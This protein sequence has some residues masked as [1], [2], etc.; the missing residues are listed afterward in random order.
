MPALLS[1]G[2]IAGCSVID[3]CPRFVRRFTKR[4]S[5]FL[6]TPDRFSRLATGGTTPWGSLF[7]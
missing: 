1:T 3:R 4:S 7:A 5:A 2:I 6:E